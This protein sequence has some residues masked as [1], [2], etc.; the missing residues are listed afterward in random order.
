MAEKAIK[1]IAISCS[2]TFSANVVIVHRLGTVFPGE[3]SVICA[4]AC[5]HR[6]EAF[7][8]CREL[9]DRLKRDVPIWKKEFA[10]RGVTWPANKP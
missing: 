4:A 2:D 3:T 7:E 9:I 10:D 8:C 6:A 1:D 5:A